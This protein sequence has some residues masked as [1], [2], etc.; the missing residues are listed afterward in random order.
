[1]RTLIIYYLTWLKKELKSLFNLKNKLIVSLLFSKHNIANNI[2]IKIIRSLK[3]HSHYIQAAM[4]LNR[5][6]KIIIYW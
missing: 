3:G 4:H 6:V 1:M 2:E 5:N